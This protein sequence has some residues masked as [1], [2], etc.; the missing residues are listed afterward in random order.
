MTTSTRLP[1]LS[2]LLVVLFIALS[3][4]ALVGGCG[5]A[6]VSQPSS[7]LDQAR[8]LSIVDGDTIWVDIDGLESKVRYIGINCPEIEHEDRPGEWLGPEATEA[9]RALVEGKTVRLEKDVSDADQHGRL[10]RYVWVGDSMIN[11]SLVSQGYA[12]AERY[13]PDVKHQARLDAAEEQ[14]RARN[15]GVWGSPSSNPDQ[16]YSC[17]ACIKG[18]INSQGQQIYHFP[19]CEAYQKTGIDLDRGERYFSSEAEARAA[20]WRRAGNCP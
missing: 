5:P 7:D 17:D 12:R 15:L 6:R 8:V 10:L 19:G 9:N 1:P 20:G 2:R 14:A 18:N 4:T 13:P 3:L 11:E 16:G